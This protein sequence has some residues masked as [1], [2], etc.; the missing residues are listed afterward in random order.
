VSAVTEDATLLADYRTACDGFADAVHAV[1]ERWDAPSP[2]KEGDTGQVF[3]HVMGA[4][5]GLLL[6]PLDVVPGDQSEDREKRWSAAID[7]LFPVLGRPGALDK[8]RLLVGILTVDVLIH[9]WD[10]SR[11]VGREL[12]LDPRLCQAGYDRSLANRVVLEE[13]GAI[14]ASV[15]VPDD[16]PIQERLLGLY[17][18]DPD[19]G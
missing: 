14:E 7:A 4:L 8:R 6:Q 11:A 9:A 2:A 15:S 18:R 1:G 17:G 16:A 13:A 19:W 10:L 3:E 5:D 12:S